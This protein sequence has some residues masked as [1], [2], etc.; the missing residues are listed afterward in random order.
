MGRTPTRSARR[1]LARNLRRIRRER[2]LSQ[3]EL[4]AEATVRQALVSAIEVGNANPTVDSL[5]RL[6]IALG[7]SINELFA[8]PQQ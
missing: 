4:A 5:E 7:V 8:D 6:A 3:D 2:E 1:I